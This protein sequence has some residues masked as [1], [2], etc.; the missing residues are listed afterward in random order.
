MKKLVYF[1]L[2]AGCILL[3]ARSVNP[4]ENFIVRL[5]NKYDKYKLN[6]RS[7]HVYVH[8]DKQ[9]YKP[10]EELWF[11]A[12]VSLEN[13][14]DT[15]VLSRDLL[16]IILDNFGQQIVWERHPVVNRTAQGYITIPKSAEYGKYTL[17][18][19][20]SWMKNMD[21]KEVYSKD[22]IINEY[23]GGEILVDLNFMSDMYLQDEGIRAEVKILTKDMQPA[24]GA[25]YSFTVN[26]LEEIV[27]KSK[28]ETDSD[29][30]SVI[31]IKLNEDMA[32]KLVTLNISVKYKGNEKSITRIIPGINNEINIVFYPEGGSIIKN[33]ESKVAFK[34]TSS[35]GFPFNFEGGLYNES[36]DLITEVKTSGNGSGVFSFIPESGHY[37]IKVTKPAIAGKEF[38][39]PEIKN[40]GI[41]LTYKGIIDDNI[42]IAATSGKP[43]E[44]E[45]T[46]WIAE[47]NNKIR[48]GA[49]VKI[50][51]AREVKIPVINFSTGVVRITVFNESELPVA[52]RSIYFNTT[53]ENKIEVRTNKSKY[54]AREK[55][56]LGINSSRAD[57][58][59]SKLNLSVSVVNKNSV[60]NTEPCFGSSREDIELAMLT[61]KSK[62]VS[63]S[64]IFST[65]VFN[66]PLYYIQD[67]FSGFLLD[68]KGNTLGNV[69][70]Q[71]IH[72]PDM[73]RYEAMSDENGIFNILFGNDVID[74]NLLSIVIS[75]K[76]GV[77]SHQV[78]AD[79]AFYDK[80]FDYFK[81][82]EGEWIKQK[83]LDI[84]AFGG[85]EMV[86]TGKYKKPKQDPL[87][88]D[89]GKKYDAERY[90]C[91]SNVLDIIHE[92]KP[93]T[94]V[95]NQIVFAGGVNSLLNQ[96]GALIVIDGAK[97]GTDI[98]ILKT[99]SPADIHN[100]NVSTNVV[101][102]H[103]YTGLNAQGIIEITTIG[104]KTK[105]EGKI[106]TGKT[107]KIDNKPEG[108]FYSPDYAV[109]DSKEEDTRTT[110][111]WNPEVI[112]N[113]G[114]EKVIS[115]Y[116]S[117]IK[118][119][120]I[121]IIEGVT[122]TGI[123]VYKEFNYIVE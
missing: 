77:Q 38:L 88:F 32:G 113:S 107:H 53:E 51:D 28:G 104:G 73:K 80:L 44:I 10:G 31:D 37:K 26:A 72:T 114:E 11:K 61:G 71:L 24:A 86:Y 13:K 25:K 81:A 58:A 106:N 83:N 47:N 84:I 3:F 27:L 55:V 118:G 119:V 1:L 39:L 4:D 41:A 120:Y 99:L 6:Y 59:P 63:Y 17:V 15:T 40:T 87:V 67:G 29:G 49:N 19:F 98:G 85:P 92:I 123:P 74:F 97:L 21:I 56:I 64:E 8:I 94:I 20:T 35:Y 91:Y 18:A 46:Y 52:E 36:G 95:D 68:K 122:S 16:I 66:K 43:D 96:Q 121:G 102:I 70:I 2:S 111:F 79:N 14:D 48:W 76:T 45:K 42:V 103:A 22:I 90:S 89:I 33:V 69:K 101:D 5:A 34:A 7:E 30:K 60:F 109:N 117:D 57:Q 105:Q 9:L 78:L 75:D 110:I 12:Y 50:M 100:I 82:D 23:S 116:T 65:S 93:F 108:I 54:S 62:D 112:F 115:F